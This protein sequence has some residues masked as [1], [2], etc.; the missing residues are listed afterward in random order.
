MDIHTLDIHTHGE[1]ELITT[2]KP[3]SYVAVCSDKGGYVTELGTSDLR[4]KTFDFAIAKCTYEVLTIE[5]YFINK[6]FAVL[7][8][9]C[10]SKEVLDGYGGLAT[11][12]S[13]IKF[14]GESLDN[15]TAV[16]QKTKKKAFLA[17]KQS[18]KTLQEELDSV[19][20]ENLLRIT[21]ASKINKSRNKYFA[22]EFELVKTTYPDFTEALRLYHSDMKPTSDIVRMRSSTNSDDR[23]TSASPSTSNSRAESSSHYLRSSSVKNE[24]SEIDGIDTDDLF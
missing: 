19:F 3:V 6:P 12:L 4:L 20:V 23:G 21:F 15:F 5:P 2:S 11:E 1:L 10:L 8:G 9:A 18:D 16:L 24:A 13:H 17:S 7:Y 14:T 22:C